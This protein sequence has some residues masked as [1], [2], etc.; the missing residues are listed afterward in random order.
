MKKLM[1]SISIILVMGIILLMGGCDKKT[2]TNTRKTLLTQ[3]LEL[4]E[5]I[6][7]MAN[8]DTYITI[9]SGNPKIAE[10]LKD[11]QDGDYTKTKA[12]YSIDFNSNSFESIIGILSGI[13]NFD[14]LS[15]DLKNVI[16]SKLKSSFATQ[17]NSLSG[18][19]ALAA[20]AICIATKTFVCEEMKE[21]TIYLYTYEDAL[22]VVVTFIKG[23][24][25]T[26]LANATF[27][28]LD[29]ALFDNQEAIE[30]FFKEFSHQIVIKEV[31][32]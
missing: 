9:F 15:D 12:I 8:S 26:V 21:D 28:F 20:S 10:K 19:E 14:N 24:D 22:P 17:I 2:D 11:V 4:V 30:K 32:R 18:A 5:L 23:E 25:E 29:K 31:E 6:E 27:L 7:E 3:G 1:K 13:A 16:K